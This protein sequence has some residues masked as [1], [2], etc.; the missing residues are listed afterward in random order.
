MFFR[1]GNKFEY[2][3]PG[4]TF[5]CVHKDRM[6]ETA[7]VVAVATDSYG[8]PHVHFRVSFQRP[9][10]NLFDGGARM[11]ALRSFADRYKE[12]VTG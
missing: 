3:R 6:E 2:I 11:L 10:L 4:S 8:I 5:K 9:D 12:R 7:Q 1:R